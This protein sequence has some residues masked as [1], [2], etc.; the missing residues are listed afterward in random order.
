[1]IEYMVLFHRDLSSRIYVRGL[2]IPLDYTIV[3]G[4]TLAISFIPTAYTQ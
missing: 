4:L 1:M 3:F 2:P